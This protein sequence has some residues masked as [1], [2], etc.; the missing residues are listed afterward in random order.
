MDKDREPGYSRTERGG[1]DGMFRTTTNL[2]LTGTFLP[3]M[4]CDIEADFHSS[5]FSAN[6]VDGALHLH[7]IED[8]NLT[9]VKVEFAGVLS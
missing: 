6:S 5:P 2:T 3:S 8:H 1:V 4:L 7:D 9:S